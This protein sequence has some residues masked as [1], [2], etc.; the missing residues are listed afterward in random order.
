MSDIDIEESE[1]DYLCGFSFGIRTFWIEA[2]D[3]KIIRVW[4]T[5]L[6][7]A[8]K[9]PKLVSVIDGI[10][11]SKKDGVCVIGEDEV[12]REFKFSIETDANASESWEWLKAND[13]SHINKDKIP[14]QLYRIKELTAECFN[15]SPPTATLF[16]SESDWEIGNETSWNIA[17][18]ISQEVFD[19]LAH[20][21]MAGDIENI[22]IGIEWK[23]GLIKDNY[24]PPS[25]P[26]DWGMIRLRADEAPQSLKGHV[27]S[28]SWKPKRCLPNNTVMCEPLPENLS[29][30]KSANLLEET[31]ERTEYVFPKSAITAL[32]TIAIGI[33]LLILK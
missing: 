7:S 27:I 22:S 6:S 29:E 21:L 16:V 26:T 25:Y 5:R 1:K 2:K 4:S 12:R 11:I 30:P 17:C 19:E 10:A 20:D 13:I 8:D 32:W 33:M 28:L 3:I 14:E 9:E 18:Q 15:E 23:L 31:V 24:A